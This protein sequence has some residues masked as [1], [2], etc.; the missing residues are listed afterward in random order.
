MSGDWV[1]LKK[2]KIVEQNKD[3]KVIL[4]IGEKKYKDKDVVISKIPSG[5]PCFY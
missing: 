4:E 1:I 2:D 3:L 5:N